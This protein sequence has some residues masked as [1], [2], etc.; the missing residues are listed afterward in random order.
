MPSYVKTHPVFIT[1]EKRNL[2]DSLGCR[3][4]GPKIAFEK[5]SII[6]LIFILII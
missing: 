1:F 5:K 4:Y 3:H 6:F 2:S